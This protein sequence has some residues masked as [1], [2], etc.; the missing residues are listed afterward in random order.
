MLRT[1]KIKQERCVRRKIRVRAKVSGSAERPRMSVHR[2]LNHFYIQLVDDRS[3]KTLCAARDTEI[4]EKGKKTDLAG[5]VGELIGA[6]ALKAGIKEVVFDKSSYQ[7]HGRVK[8]AAEGARK[9][10]LKF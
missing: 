2:S 10:G 9:A 1:Q 3:G 5:K 6:K 8:A 4:K 7:Y